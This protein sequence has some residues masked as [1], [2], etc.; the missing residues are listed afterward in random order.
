MGAGQLP[1]DIINIIN[2]ERREIFK[3]G[4]NGVSDDKT[5]ELCDAKFG[6]GDIG[7]I[8]KALKAAGV[9]KIAIIGYIKRPDFSKISFDFGGVKILPKLISAAKQGDDAIMRVILENF[10]Q[11][12]INIIGPEILFPQ[13]FANSGVLGKI[14][15]SENDLFDISKAELINNAIG[16]FD[17]GQAIVV[18]NGVVLAIE[19]QE[20]T[21]EMLKRISAL[22]KHLIGNKISK[23]GILFKGPKSIQDLRI[24]LP[25]IGIKTLENAIN[26]NL[27]GI[28]YIEGQAI[29]AQKEILI[30][31]AN[32]AGIFL[33]GIKRQ[34]NA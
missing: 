26:A 21:D 33:F 11:E 32:E 2:Q 16:E 23:N 7:K 31:R 1:F 13:I 22:P 19:A 4:I 24:D 29:L 10:E 34:N 9:E 14:S 5:L 6:L 17:I 3:I 15:P 28:A 27:S 18:A 8:I 30:E 25:T 20:G 12:G